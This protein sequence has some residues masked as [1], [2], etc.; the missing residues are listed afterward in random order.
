MLPSLSPAVWQPRWCA[1]RS[2]DRVACS[3]PTWPSLHWCVAT[4]LVRHR[5]CQPW[6]RRRRKIGF[7][8]IWKWVP[9]QACLRG[10]EI[11]RWPPAPSIS[12]HLSRRPPP[13]GVTEYSSASTA[14]ARGHALPFK[15]IDPK[16]QLHPASPV[17]QIGSCMT[18]GSEPRWRVSLSDP[19]VSHGG[20]RGRR[21]KVT[22]RGRPPSSLSRDSLAAM[23]ALARNFG[24]HVS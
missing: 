23:W 20:G 1:I 11:C 5:E 17:L 21:W 8:S 16:L 10:V 18:H 6:R 19:E 3:P 2:A 4:A 9:Q 13:A 24:R 12:G 7:A 14:V 22:S 15:A